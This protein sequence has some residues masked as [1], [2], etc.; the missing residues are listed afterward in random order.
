MLKKTLLTVMMTTLLATS[1]QAAPLLESGSGSGSVS[2]SGSGENLLKPTSPAGEQHDQKAA[3]DLAEKLQSIKTLSASYTLKSQ[4]DRRKMQTESGEMQIKRPN[5]FRWD[6]ASPYIQ[7]TISRDEKVWIIEPAVLQVVIKR[8]DDSMGA[9]PVQLLSGDA[10][11]FLEDYRVIRINYDSEQTYTLRPRNNN[12]PF[13]QL[14]V[15]F[16]QDKLSGITLKDNLGGTR[17]ISF[18]DVKMNGDIDDSRFKA[19]YSKDFDVIDET[20]S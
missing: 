15:S 3:T 2:G 6:V 14:D 18:S 7:H 4:S 20:R 1:L 17:Q 10:K 13:K 19:D 9:T 12:G 16:R 5:Q 11:A 8:Q